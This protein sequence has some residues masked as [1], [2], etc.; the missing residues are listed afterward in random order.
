MT[1]AV[2]H[3]CSDDSTIETGI[4]Q[5]IGVECRLIA[6]RKPPQQAMNAA[7]R[8]RDDSCVAFAHDHEPTAR[9]HGPTNE[10]RRRAAP[11][12]Q[13]HI[14]VRA[15]GEMEHDRC[16]GIGAAVPFCENGPPGQRT[17]AC[18][19][20]RETFA[21]CQS[22]YGGGP[23]RSSDHTRN[24]TL[25]TTHWQ[26]GELR[27]NP[28]NGSLAFVSAM[29]GRERIIGGRHGAKRHRRKRP[30]PIVRNREGKSPSRPERTSIILQQA[31][32]VIEFKLGT[33]SLAETASKLF[34]D[35]AGPLG[36]DLARHLDGGIVAI[37]PPAQGP[38]QRVGFLLRPG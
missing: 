10:P 15:I 3:D 4:D 33:I 38:A 16:S 11:L 6:R 14:H 26:P 17:E 34:K 13:H 22:D 27:Q 32:D 7:T 5:L 20:I 35:T 25:A 28:T 18:V 2:R 12:H 29:A 37:I 23:A 31:L 9:Q 21:V 24:D 8:L 1:P 19:R 30:P 36:I